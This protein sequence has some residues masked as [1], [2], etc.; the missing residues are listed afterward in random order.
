M[1]VAILDNMSSS[2]MRD[3]MCMCKEEL[4]LIWRR[5]ACGLTCCCV[6]TAHHF[7]QG[8]S[9]GEDPRGGRLGKGLV[10]LVV[11]FFGAGF[12]MGWAWGQET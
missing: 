8:C 4:P 9:Q 12:G 6:D 11:F 10:R 2:A 1:I 3:R 7:R 5:F